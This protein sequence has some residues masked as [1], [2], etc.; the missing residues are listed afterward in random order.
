MPVS[1]QT[2]YSAKSMEILFLLEDEKYFKYKV[3][4][5]QN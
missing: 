3:N 4:K 5:G 1:T 2:K